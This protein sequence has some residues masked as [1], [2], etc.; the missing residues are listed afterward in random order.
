M[1]P[2]D[3]TPPKIEA[4]YEES[5]EEVNWQPYPQNGLIRMPSTKLIADEKHHLYT[6]AAE[7]LPFVLSGNPDDSPLPGYTIIE[8]SAKHDGLHDIEQRLSK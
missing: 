2:H 1:K 4:L 6:I 3:L 7:L 8:A 5:L